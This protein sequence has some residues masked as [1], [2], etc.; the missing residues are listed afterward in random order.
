MVIWSNPAKDDLR[1]IHD[2]IAQD[3][4]FY[5]LKVTQEFIEKSEILEEFPKMGRV[6]PEIGE[7]NIRELF[8]YS[9]RFI[10]EISSDKIE[11][12]AIIHGRQ[13]F[14]GAIDKRKK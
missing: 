9:Y 1:K 6:V 3:S 13:D 8:L 2:Y 7:V 4:K 5:A 14:L 11:I 12:L 10:Y